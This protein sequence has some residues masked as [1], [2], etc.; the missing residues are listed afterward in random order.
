MLEVRKL[1]SYK[2]KISLEDAV[3][4]AI[5]EVTHMFNSS[6]R[7]PTVFVTSDK[8]ASEIRKRSFFAQVAE[9]VSYKLP[10]EQLYAN[11]NALDDICPLRYIAC[12]RS[13]YRSAS[14]ICNNVLSPHSGAVLHSFQRA[15]PAD[16]GD[17]ISSWKLSVDKDQLPHPNR[18]AHMLFRSSKFYSPQNNGLPSTPISALFVQWSRFLYDDMAAI[19]PYRD[20]DG[21]LPSCCPESD[22]PECAP[23]YDDN[24]PHE[25]MAGLG[26]QSYVRSQIAPSARCELGT[27]QQMNMASSFIDAE[28]IYGNTIEEALEKRTRKNGNI[29]Q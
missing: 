22:H 17:E 10:R 23:L 13:K 5:V 15:L 21:K 26:C 6:R 18:I 9:R 20:T 3:L 1:K 2:R 24:D 14:G 12:S 4:D 29:A 19:V 16:Y 28:P 8:Q 25:I 7:D 11:R 27:R